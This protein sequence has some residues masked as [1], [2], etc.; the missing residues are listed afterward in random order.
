MTYNEATGDYQNDY[1]EEFFPGGLC[2]IPYKIKIERYKELIKLFNTEYGFN[3]ENRFKSSDVI[4]V[5]ISYDDNV[6]WDE[7][8][9]H[10]TYTIFVWPK[11]YN[12][13]DMYDC[14]QFNSDDT[15]K[16][17]KDYDQFCMELRN[18]IIGIDK[19]LASEIREKLINEV[20][21][22]M[23]YINDIGRL[24]NESK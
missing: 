1:M 16:N 18:C 6:S 23:K 13:D 14:F 2:N 8:T 3:F 5:S 9:K 12:D 20:T 15:E 10:R 19:E 11:T 22:N 4:T 24:I 17:K 21:Q 7:L